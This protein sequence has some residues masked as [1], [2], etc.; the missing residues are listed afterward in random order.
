[1]YLKVN[2]Q[3]EAKALLENMYH[4]NQA[5]VIVHHWAKLS[6]GDFP[7]LSYST[8]NPVRT[9]QISAFVH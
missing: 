3:T 2:L 7:E 1:M 5:S 9:F 8:I 4:M 6:G